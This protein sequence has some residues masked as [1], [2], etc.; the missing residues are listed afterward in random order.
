MDMSQRLQVLGLKTN[1]HCQARNCILGGEKWT[2]HWNRIDISDFCCQTQ[3][4]LE[5]KL[6]LG[7]EVAILSAWSTHR[8]TNPATHPTTQPPNP[9]ASNPVKFQIDMIEAR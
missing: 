5:L 7:A 4:Q 6:Q 9:Q 8:P 2:K 1:A 3:P